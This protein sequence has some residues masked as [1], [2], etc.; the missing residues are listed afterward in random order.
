MSFKLN[1]VEI[2][3][4]LFEVDTDNYEEAN[5]LLKEAI[6]EIDDPA[7]IDHQILYALMIRV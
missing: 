5:A 1:V 7:V 6:S 2:R 4:L 3:T